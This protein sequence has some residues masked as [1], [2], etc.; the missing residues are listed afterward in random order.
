MKGELKGG[1]SYHARA[2]NRLESHEGRIE[3]SLKRSS[4]SSQDTSSQNLMKGE[5]K[6]GYSID[7][8]EIRPVRN[9]MKG[10]LKGEKAVA[11]KDKMK[12]KNLM[13]GE[14]KE[15]IFLRPSHFVFPRLNLMK[16]ELKGVIEGNSQ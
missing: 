9:L 6:E 14:L 11:K 3:R 7:V 12:A 4:A 5:L 13:K 2:I 1:I 10:E 15:V 16:G 8:L